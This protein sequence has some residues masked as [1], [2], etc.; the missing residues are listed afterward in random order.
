MALRFPPYNVPRHCEGR[1]SPP[2]HEADTLP[3][4]SRSPSPAD[5]RSGNAVQDRCCGTLRLRGK[6]VLLAGIGSGSEYGNSGEGLS[7]VGCG[8]ID[9]PGGT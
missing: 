6:L 7:V 9:S 2:T 4:P 1:I 3:H 8:M 5:C